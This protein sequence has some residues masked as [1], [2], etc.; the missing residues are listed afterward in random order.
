MNDKKFLAENFAHRPLGMRLAML[1]R[2][3]RSVIDQALIDTGLTQSRWTV[4]MQLQVVERPLTVSELAFAMG[5]ELP[6]LTR[7]LNQLVE[8][9]LIVR[10]EDKDDRRIRLVTLS[11]QGKH[12]VAQVNRVVEECQRKVSEGLPAEQLDQFS[13]TLNLLTENMSKLV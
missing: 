8:S 2:L 1:A 3:W 5:I 12:Q 9:G 10:V 4:L 11:E 7:T 6:P 13:Q